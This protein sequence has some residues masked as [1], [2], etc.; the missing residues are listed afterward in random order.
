MQ[1]LNERM[2]HTRDMSYGVVVCGHEQVD[3][4]VPHAHSVL[5]KPILGEPN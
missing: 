2:S 3:K 5:F 4:H 1:V